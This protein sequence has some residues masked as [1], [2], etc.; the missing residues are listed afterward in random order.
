MSRN[1][2]LGRVDARRVWFVVLRASA[3][4]FVVVDCI[5]VIGLSRA[6]TSVLGFVVL[7]V[8]VCGVFVTAGL[9]DRNWGLS[10]GSLPEGLSNDL[11]TLATQGSFIRNLH[12][13]GVVE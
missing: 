11:V 12:P 7:V 1:I 9:T 10:D 2:L 5:L 8:V 3:C 4:S 6:C 13:S